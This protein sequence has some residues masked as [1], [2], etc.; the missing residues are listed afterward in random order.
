[1]V[2][3]PLSVWD[4]SDSWNLTGRAFFVLDSVPAGPGLVD[5][6]SGSASLLEIALLLSHMK[7]HPFNRII[8]AW[9][10]AEV[11]YSSLVLILGCIL[12]FFFF[13]LLESPTTLGTWPPRLT[14]LRPQSH[15]K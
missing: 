15:L 1:V 3:L 7:F 11:F 10:G 4:S 13:S 5:N 14:A 2:F 8:F 12:L 9:W 6:G